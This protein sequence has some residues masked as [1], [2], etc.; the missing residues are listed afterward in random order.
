MMKTALNSVRLE[1]AGIVLALPVLVILSVVPANSWVGEPPM[2]ISTTPALNE[3]NVAA[4]TDLTMSFNQDMDSMSICDSTLIVHAGYSGLRQGLFSYDHATRTARF[5]PASDFLPGEEV[6][7]LLTT[8]VRSVDTESLQ[9][10][11]VWSFKVAAEYGTATFE[12]A[13]GVGTGTAP[14]SIV[15]ADLDNDGDI[16]LATSNEESW[17]V[18]VMLNSGAGEF[19]TPI[20]YAVDSFPLSISAAD[21]DRDGDIDLSTSNFFSTVSILLNN[22]DGTFEPHIDHAVWCTPNPHGVAD[23]N[24]DGHLD[25][26][27]T[28]LWSHTITMLISDGEG[29]F[30]DYAYFTVPV[31]PNGLATVDLDNDAD[32]DLSLGGY[33]AQAVT[34]LLNDGFAGFTPDSTYDIGAMVIPICAADLDADGD[35]DMVTGNHF[36]S[37]IS[38]LKNTGGG[39]LEAFANFA[40][41][42]RPTSVVAA[43]LDADGDLDLATSN[44]ASR[45]VSVLTN[46]GDADFAPE[47]TYSAAM[48]PSDLVAADLNGDGALDL[49]VSNYSS[50]TVTVLLNRTC[51]DSDGDGYGDPEYPGNVCPVDNCPYYYNPKQEDSDGDGIGDICDSC[52]D[53]DSDGYGDLSYPATTCAPDNCIDIYN[54]DQIDTDADGQGDSCDAI[55]VT[56]TADVRCGSPPLT[57]SFN[58]L[59]VSGDNLSSWSWDFGDS[60][61]SA[62]QHPTHEYLTVGTFDVTLIVSDGVIADTLAQPNFVTTQEALS[63]DFESVPRNGKTPLTVVFEPLLTGEANE[64]NWDFGDGD[65]STLPNPIH[66]YQTTGTYDVT[67][68]V[69]M[70]LG[71]CDQQGLETKPEYIVASDLDAQFSANPIAGSVPLT[72]QFIDSSGGEPIGWL[73]DF[74]DENSSTDRNPVHQYNSV[75]HYDV[76]LTVDDGAKTDSLLKLEYIH[77]DSNYIDMEVE[78]FW[79]GTRPGFYFPYWATWTNRGTVATDSC[80]LKVLLPQ[81]TDFIDIPAFIDQS[82]GGTGT[83]DGYSFAG[84]TL[85]VPLGIIHPSGFYGGVIRISNYCPE[86]VQI[87]DSLFCEAWLESSAGESNTNNNYAELRDDTYGSVDPNHKSATPAGEGALKSIHTSQ[88]LAYLVQF[89]NMPEAT[90]SAIYVRVVDT[91]DPGLDWGTLSVGAMSHPGTCDWDFDPYTGVITWFCDSI[92]LPPNHN[93]PEG[94][95]W[96]TY[97]ISP[98]PDLA[99]GTEIANTAWI[100]FDYNPWLQAPETG[101]VIRTIGYPSCCGQYTGGMTG[102]CNC[103]IDGKRNLADISKLIDRVYIT[104]TPLC[105]EENGNVNGDIDAKINLADISRLIDHVYITKQETAECE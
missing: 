92:M 72:V 49:A 87:G 94:E 50:N 2:V 73:W 82:N 83:F 36:A 41:G 27:T 39:T 105:C 67:L 37:T 43:D 3:L 101:P 55:T 93:P 26:I 20:T 44:E 10:G 9:Q 100:R 104:K 69:R 61:T 5:D 6:T 34:V 81:Q 7:V 57:V 85:I 32:I 23:L 56:F 33:E 24:V 70:N 42:Q 52:T 95:G 59:S 45:T 18:S 19:G 80:V 22:S 103:D 21:L 25:I 17:D 38:V 1:V 40:V 46:N 77:A 84:D 90:A 29:S 58:D 47:D 64:Y 35:V 15:A 78:L 75:G 102:N 63:A 54:P 74:G 60:T 86:T 89:E 99:P 11:Y 98:K 88:R 91:L 68:T 53:V 12:S 79:G 16:D 97:S 62:E 65:T 96:F 48:A 4:T 51:Y 71:D 76:S 8:G 66:T 31:D 14:R 30:L 28:N 13:D